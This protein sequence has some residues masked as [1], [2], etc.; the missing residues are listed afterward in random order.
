MHVC[1]STVRRRIGS[2]ALAPRALTQITQHTT[3]PEHLDRIEPARDATRQRGDHRARQREEHDRWP[4]NEREN[5]ADDERQ[6]RRRDQG[7]ALPAGVLVR[8]LGVEVSETPS[9]RRLAEPVPHRL[10][11][12]EHAYAGLQIAYQHRCWLWPLAAAFAAAKST[13]SA[14]DDRAPTHRDATVQHVL[15]RRVE[16]MVQLTWLEL[17]DLIQPLLEVFRQ[18]EVERRQA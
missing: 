3:A 2:G 13:Q 7:A 5:H 1:V 10:G 12:V 14:R 6:A 9:R 18:R 11:L 17:A 15:H 16:E 8:V 4:R